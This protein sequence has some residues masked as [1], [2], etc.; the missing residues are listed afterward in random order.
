M[1]RLVN[2]TKCI[3]TLLSLGTTAGELGFLVN[4]CHFT[5]NSWNHSGRTQGREGALDSSKEKA[6]SWTLR[7]K[8]VF[9]GL[10]EVIIS[11]E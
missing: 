4:V 6:G 7:G 3:M 1:T 10:M 11:E 8:L 2:V 9:N 5:V